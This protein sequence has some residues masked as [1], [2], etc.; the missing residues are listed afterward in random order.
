MIAY[1]KVGGLRFVRLGRLTFMWC[2]R[3]RTTVTL[4]PSEYY[5]R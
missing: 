2:V 5:W 4:Q 1:K 3:R